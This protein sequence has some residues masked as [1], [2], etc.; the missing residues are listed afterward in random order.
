MRFQRAFSLVVTSVCLATTGIV[1]ARVTKITI[2]S[3]TSV[4]NTGPVGPYEQLRGEAT[5]EIDPLDRRNAIIT[6]IQFAPK[7]A[8][9]KV[10]YTTQFTLLKPVD[11]S[12]SSGI[13][14]ESIPNRGGIATPYGTDLLF[15]WG[16][17]VLNVAWQGD[18]PITGTT[19]NL[20][21]N[22]P[23]ATGVVGPVWDRLSHP[24]A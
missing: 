16:E 20:G 12:N 15:A 21:I 17:S 18:L 23:R 22:V 2:Q 10:E 5:G 9:G 3:T 24:A 14:V 7:N 8:N 4:A 13:M 1:D 11:M 19:G 6:D